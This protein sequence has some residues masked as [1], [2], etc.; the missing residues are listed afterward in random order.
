MRKPLLHSLTVLSLFASPWG[1]AIVYGEAVNFSIPQG[2]SESHPLVRPWNQ[3][4][5]QL[6]RIRN[7]LEDYSCR[8]VKRERIGGKLQQYRFISVKVRRRGESDRPFSVY[9][10]YLGPKPFSGRR[11]LYVEGEN[12][13][14]M[15][16]RQATGLLGSVTLKIATN[17]MAARRESLQPIT[18]VG[19]ERMAASLLVKLAE[20]MEADPT[21]ENTQVN[22]IPGA[23]IDDRRCTCIRVTHAE[24]DEQF[25][26]H[27]AEVFVDDEHQLPVRVVAYDW[28]TANGV[29]PPLI[30]E[31]NYTR[32]N[33]NADF[34]DAD[35]ALQ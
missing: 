21:G 11:V 18:D 26:F 5:S 33:L 9:L 34:T 7:T 1:G 17:G 28:P 35:F 16:V 24:P 4:S 13:N 20:E 14:R 31:Y 23:T 27:A 15:L 6:H 29:R 32:L 10:Q 22:Y 3:V 30:S 19:F 8:L 12:D 25:T 2:V